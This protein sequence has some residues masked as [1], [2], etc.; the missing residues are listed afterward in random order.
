M[1]KEIYFLGFRNLK[2]KK[3][4]LSNSFNLIYGENAQGKTSFMEAIYFASSG[5]S[6]RTKKNNEMLKYGFENAKVY[7]KINSLSNYAI[8]L[9]KNEKKCYKNGK[10]I[11][12]LDYIGDILAISFIPEDVELIMASPSIRRAFFNYEISQ[13]N[14]EYLESIVEY[15][16]ILKIRN[17]FLKEKKIEDEL[18]KIYN[19]MYIKLCA[20]ILKIRKE[21]IEKLNV[22]LDRKY[23]ELFNSKQKLYITYDNFMKVNEN[24]EIDEL[25]D[26]IRKT[27]EDKL[28]M[29][30]QLTYSIYGIHKDEYIFNLNDKNAKIYSSQGEK[31]SIIFVTKISQ[32]ELMEEKTNRKAIFLMDDIA[33]FFDNFRRNQIINYFLEKEI[34]CFLTSTEDLKIEGKKFYLEEGNIIEKY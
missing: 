32:L 29:E 24:L 12:Y 25:E 9:F 18:F 13:I 27:L 6:F 33:S 8:D 34:Q 16:K 11:R 31:K 26:S 10:R 28:N 30:L 21:Y 3:I 14:R 5:R 19:N 2:D 7:I 4:K 23:K 17:K 20:K 1:I 22:I 15:E